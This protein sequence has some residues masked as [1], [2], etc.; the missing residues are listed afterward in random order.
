MRLYVYRSSQCEELKEA[1]IDG[2][3]RYLGTFDAK[4]KIGEHQ[5]G[6]AKFNALVVAEMMDASEELVFIEVSQPGSIV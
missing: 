4:T 6:E 3:I 2:A 5:L 1:C